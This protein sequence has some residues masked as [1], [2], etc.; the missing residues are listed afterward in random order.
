MVSG[1]ESCIRYMYRFSHVQSALASSEMLYVR[2]RQPAV[3]CS[4]PE[5]S[6][7]RP[8]PTAEPRCATPRWHHSRGVVWFGL[9]KQMQVP[10]SYHGSGPF[11][12][13][14]LLPVGYPRG[15]GGVSPG[16]PNAWTWRSRKSGPRRKGATSVAALRI[17]GAVTRP[18][19]VQGTRAQQGH[20]C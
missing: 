1:C 9:D 11:G 14:S 19:K 20:A 2:R 4:S 16:R 5:L 15:R 8:P 3:I 6:G 7:A 13:P 12:R 18:E 17:P 10:L